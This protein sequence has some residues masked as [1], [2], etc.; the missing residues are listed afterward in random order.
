MKALILH[1]LDGTRFVC[2]VAAA[3]A[4][5]PTRG[6]HVVD[7][8]GES[9]DVLETLDE[10]ANALNAEHVLSD[11]EVADRVNQVVT[12]WRPAPFAVPDKPR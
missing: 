11:E 3:Y 8:A 6:H 12:V 4:P 5:G 2:V 10:I 7:V 1:R 9:S